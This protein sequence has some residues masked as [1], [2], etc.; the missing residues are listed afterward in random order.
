MEPFLSGRTIHCQLCWLF[1]N[2]HFLEETNGQGKPFDSMGPIP[3][4]T[5]SEEIAIPQLV[6]FVRVRQSE[7]LLLQPS[8]KLMGRTEGA[9]NRTAAVMLLL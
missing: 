3:G 9:L 7:I 6:G 4:V 8:P 2:S 1:R 5:A